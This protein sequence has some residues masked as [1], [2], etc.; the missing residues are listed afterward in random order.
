MSSNIIT[1]GDIVPDFS[2][3]AS[4]GRTVGSAQLVGTPFLIY[5]YPKADTSGC[6]VQACGIQEALPALGQVGLQ[7]IG[8]SPDPIRAIERFAAKFDLS[9][10]LASDADHAV[11]ERF[12]CWVEKSMYG[13]KYWGMERSSF[14]VDADGVVRHF[15][16]KVKPASHAGDVRRIAETCLTPGTPERSP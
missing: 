10:P 2:L 7:V 3:P 1:V 12:G 4:N 5:F 8:V 13:R 11:A 16:R 6:T 9:F 14:L 15:W